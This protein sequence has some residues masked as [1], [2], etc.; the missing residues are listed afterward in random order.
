MDGIR[1]HVAKQ[2]TLAKYR[3]RPLRHHPILD[4]D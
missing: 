2:N 4:I 3:D 1:T